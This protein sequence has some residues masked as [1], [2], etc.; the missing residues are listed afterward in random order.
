[1]KNQ[2]EGR[3]TNSVFLKG[4]KEN[5]QYQPKWMK[6]PQYEPDDHFDCC[7]H[8]NIMISSGRRFYELVPIKIYK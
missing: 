8:E 4:M 3:S 2:K 7:T 5:P 1:M 6:N